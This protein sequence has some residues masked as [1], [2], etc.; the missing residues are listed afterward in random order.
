MNFPF[1]T[2]LSTSWIQEFGLNVNH[3]P[4]RIALS[5][6]LGLS[7]LGV[8]RGNAPQ[9]SN[10]RPPAV[11]LVVFSPFLSIWSMA[12]KLTDDVTRHWT[13]HAHA[14]TSM[15]RVDGQSFRLMGNQP[16]DVPP[17]PQ[18]GLKVTPTRSIYEF[19]NKQVHVT[20][21]FETPAMPDDINALTRPATYLIWNVRAIDGAKHAVSVFDGTSSAI[22]VNEPS[23]KVVWSRETCGSLTALKAGTAEQAYVQL[24]GDDAR[25]NWGYVYAA[26]DSKLSTSAMG[27]D[28]ALFSSFVSTGK[29]PTADDTAMPRAVNS[30][31][32]TLGFV[33]NFGVVDKKPIAR[34]LMVAYDEVYAIK[35]FGQKLRPFWRRGGTTP[36]TMLQTAEKQFDYEGQQ[37][38]LFDRFLTDDLTAVGGPKYGQIG[39]LAYRQCLAGTG[40]AA[41]AN[42]QPLMFTKENTS[43]GDIATVDVIFPMAPMWILLNPT[44]AKASIVPILS[45]AASDHWKFPNAPHD[46][47]TYPIAKGT[48]DGGEG[49]PVEESGNMLILCDAIAQTDNST[50]W[51]DPWWHKL[52]QWAKYLEQYGLD[53][54][55]QLCTDDFMGHLAHNANLS[56]KAILGLAAYGD[57]CR[58]RGDQATAL[59]YQKL[60]KADAAHWMTVGMEGDHGKLAFDQ[61]NTWS[62]KYNLVWDSI[63]DLN[64]FPPSLAEKEVAYYKSKLQK[65]GVPLDSRTHLTKTDWS[66]WSATLARDLDSFDAITGPIWDYM[67][68]TSTREAMVDSYIT[69]DLKSNGM[70]ARPVI[71]GVFIKLLADRP[72]WKKWIDF[73]NNYHPTNWA[74]LPVPPKLI[75]LVPTSRTSAQ[76][77]KMTLSKPSDDWTKAGFDDSTWTVAMGPFGSDGTPGIAPKTQWT[78]DDIWL[79]REIVVPVLKGDPCVIAYHD[80][81]VEIYFNGV[82]AAKENGYVNSYE[83]LELLP[84]AKALLKS[85]S[86]I[87]ISVHCHQ[88]SGGQ[89][90]DVGIGY[91]QKGK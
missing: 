10:L 65:Y 18:V 76:T 20:L 19:E 41:D 54:E 62:Q 74:P 34:H 45:Y 33:F 9:Q 3:H 44:M 35:Y 46:L 50:K 23:E 15:I 70:H 25:I 88:T 22:S 72:K 58:I 43:N 82:L 17:M 48:D 51:L 7:I 77:W 56:I 40:I 14:L 68:T 12:D 53:P 8:A 78:S 29:L 47:G 1:R 59:R 91:L 80:E 83:P 57:L 5:T 30:D 32:P 38:D 84:A 52:T 66:Y 61:P 85:G 37:C 2:T 16:K 36:S 75:E 6:V 63:L 13:H 60:A 73:D 69:D 26:A 89:G 79:R 4:F 21:T 42:G 81:D 27:S 11:P 39:A 31:E 86:K 71:G 28:K 49:M 87:T 24:A 55:D 67:N 64:I 90:V